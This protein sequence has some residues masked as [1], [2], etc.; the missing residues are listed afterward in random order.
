MRHDQSWM[1]SRKNC[2][3]LVSEEFINGVDGF[4]QVSIRDLIIVDI[5]W[6]ILC[7]CAKCRNSYKNKPFSVEKHLY[8]H[9]FVDDYVN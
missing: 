6:C 3:G 5:A 7:P 9:E 8:D 4:I 2:F 1:L